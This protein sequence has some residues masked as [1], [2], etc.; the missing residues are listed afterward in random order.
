MAQP[1]I[2]AQL[3]AALVQQQTYIDQISDGQPIDEETYRQMSNLSGQAHAAARAL[4]TSPGETNA[5]PNFISL[6][7]ESLANAVRNRRR[8]TAWVCTLARDSD[9][10]TQGRAL[11][12]LLLLRTDGLFRMRE[13]IVVPGFVRLLVGYV[14]DQQAIFRA[15]M[16]LELLQQLTYNRVD[17]FKA[18][19]VE[20]NGIEV[21]LR[22][23]VE[24]TFHDREPV[25]YTHLTLPTI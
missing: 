17:E 10:E 1:D 25:S 4:S 13:L 8:S 15:K 18:A 3:T 14:G 7:P 22:V 21:A 11:Q 9:L 6:N 16:A 24:N 20:A 2:V 19:L 5:I 23:V 12:A